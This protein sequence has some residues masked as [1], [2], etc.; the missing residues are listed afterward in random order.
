MI[1][2]MF[3]LYGCAELA[4]ANGLV[5]VFAGGAAIRQATKLLDYTKVTYAFAEQLERL[6][7]TAILFIF[8]GTLFNASLPPLLSP[9]FFFVLIA[10]FAL[11]PRSW[12]NST[13]RSVGGAWPSGFQQEC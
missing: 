1:G 10:L 5:A 6:L 8:G 13:M 11:R 3:F 9:E 4:S 2:I 12:K 7:M